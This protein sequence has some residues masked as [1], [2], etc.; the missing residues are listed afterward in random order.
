MK[1]KYE[2]VRKYYSPL[3]VTDTLSVTIKNAYKK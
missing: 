1:N 2:A 3:L